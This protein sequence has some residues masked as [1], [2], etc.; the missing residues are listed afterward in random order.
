MGVGWGYSFLEIVITN[1]EPRFLLGLSRLMWWCSVVVRVRD[2]GGGGLVYTR[3]QCC[4]LFVQHF[5]P[6]PS[7]TLFRH[8]KGRVVNAKFRGVEVSWG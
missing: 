1:M 4:Y 8:S 5:E 3:R 6:R 7:V 2:W